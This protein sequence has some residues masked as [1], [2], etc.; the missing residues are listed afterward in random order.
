VNERLQFTFDTV[1]D[2]PGIIQGG[3]MIEAIDVEV[4]CR[5]DAATFPSAT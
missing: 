4:G 5:S 3:S 1:F 2:E